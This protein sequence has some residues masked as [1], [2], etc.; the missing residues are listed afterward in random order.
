MKEGDR[1]R[2]WIKDEYTPSNGEV[3]TVQFI[4]DLGTIFIKFDSGK[5]LGAVRS[6]DRVELI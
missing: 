6:V 1:V 2:A 4:D 5:D 3:G